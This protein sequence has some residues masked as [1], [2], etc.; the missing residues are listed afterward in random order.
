MQVPNR[1][2]L[3]AMIMLIGDRATAL[4]SLAPIAKLP[5]LSPEVQLWLTSGGTA[6]PPRQSEGSAEGAWREA[7]SLLAQSA[8]RAMR[9]RSVCEADG[10]AIVAGARALPDGAAL[11]RSATLIT[12][13]GRAV[14]QNLVLTMG[15]RGLE[16]FGMPGE[17]TAFDPVR[18]E[19]SDG[20]AIDTATVTIIEPGALRTGPTGV[21]DVVRKATV[22][23][24]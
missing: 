17:A 20:K 11:V 16:V 3:A 15:K 18:H 4:A 19:A 24:P 7:D 1:D 10:A 12:N 5:G 21:V 22:R 2:L 9:L 6:Q 13:L 14:A 8:A 23:T